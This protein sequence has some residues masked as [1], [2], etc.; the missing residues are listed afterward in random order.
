MVKKESGKSDLSGW[1]WTFFHYVPIVVIVSILFHVGNLYSKTNATSSSSVDSG[2]SF[3]TD[4]LA[5]V[6]MGYSYEVT[7]L[8]STLRE[9]V[10]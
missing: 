10:K 9:E 7:R 5:I 6:R 4:V 3:D 8:L 1:Y 2:S